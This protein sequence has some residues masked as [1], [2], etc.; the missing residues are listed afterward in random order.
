[1]NLIFE[2]V[3]LKFKIKKFTNKNKSKFKIC[4]FFEFRSSFQLFQWNFT[5]MEFYFNGL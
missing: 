1:M 3:L 2:T 5:L 4:T